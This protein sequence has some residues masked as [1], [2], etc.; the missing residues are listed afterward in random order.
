MTA[1]EE[2]QAAKDQ[3]KDWVNQYRLIWMNDYF[4]FDGKT[5]DC[6]DRGVN[7]IQARILMGI[8]NVIMG[9]PIANALPAGT[10][11]RDCDNV[12]HEVTFLYMVQMAVTLSTFKSTAYQVSWDM[13]SAIDAM[14]TIE[15]V[16]ALEYDSPT[17]WP[18]RD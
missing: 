1:E 13:K 12:N 14:T 16:N 17:Y 2:L 3:K 5:W 4:T 7:N 11:F 18:N 10:L 8:L 6:D 15:E 9:V